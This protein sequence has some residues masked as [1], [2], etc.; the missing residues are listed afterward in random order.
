[1]SRQLPPARSMM[2]PFIRRQ[3]VYLSDVRK[4]NRRTV[5]NFSQKVIKPEFAEAVVNRLHELVDRQSKPKDVVMPIRA[6]IEAGAINRPTW[7]EFC[8]EFGEERVNCKSSYS[9]YTNDNYIYNGEG[10]K[11]MI[12]DFRAIIR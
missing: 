8:G 12:E 5:C 2:F 10:F 7:T 6:A 4:W 9:K 1:M 3:D 11:K